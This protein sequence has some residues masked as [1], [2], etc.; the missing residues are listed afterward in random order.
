M[1]HY[2]SKII[3][4]DE[5]SGLIYEYIYTCMVYDSGN[6]WVDILA[7]TNVAGSA[8]S[9][10]QTNREIWDVDGGIFRKCRIH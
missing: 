9:F 2:I 4:D 5:T 1:K 3:N 8:L 6:L 10:A 7:S